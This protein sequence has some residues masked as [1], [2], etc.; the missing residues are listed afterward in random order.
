MALTATYDT[1]LGRV[2][3]AAS[4]LGGTATNCVIDRTTDSIRY[5]VV[6]GGTSRPVAAGNASVDD[7][8][9][10]PGVATTYRLRSYTAG[11]A[12]VDTVTATI[13]QDVDS[14]W[15][16]VPSA[17]YLN[18]RVDVSVRLEIARRSRGGVF[19]VVGRTFPVAV[20]DIRGGREFTLP[21]R[22][23]TAEEERALDYALATGSVVFL[24]VP[25]AEDQFPTGYYFVGAVSRAPERRYTS[26]R[27][28]ALELT[29][30]A[31]PGPE[32]IGSTYTCASVLTDYATVAAMVA[33]N[34]T[35]ADLL[36]RTAS[37]SEVIVP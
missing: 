11:G 3:V 9:F 12:L 14:A 30:V 15:L 4:G 35:I 32:V 6:R 22:T 33:A 16:K 37:P 8:E 36:N 2:R 20:G 1:V 18:M 26:R 31:A 24:Q 25:F 27:I 21:I 10:A 13:T 7:Y 17:P 28:W 34:A 19:D 23:Q 5:T 29:E